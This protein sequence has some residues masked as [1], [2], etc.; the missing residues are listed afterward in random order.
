MDILTANDTPAC[1]PPSF[2]ASKAPIPAQRPDVTGDLDCDVCVIGAG[3][4][5]LSSA[6]HLARK[7]YK[8][9]VLDAHRVGWGASGRNGGHAGNG[10]RVGQTDLERIVGEDRARL[11]WDMGIASV[12]LVRDLVSRHDIACDLGRGII[13]ACN[14]PGAVASSHRNAENLRTKYDYDQIEVL[15]RGRLR[16]IVGTDAYHGGT[17][18]TG[19]AHLDPLA[20]VLGLARAAEAAGAVIHE[21]SRVTGVDQGSPA[22]VRTALARIRARFV[23]LATNGYHGDLFPALSQHVMPINNYIVATEPLSQSCADGLIKGGYA[24]AD[25]KFVI[26]YFRL[27]P[28]RRLIF[29]GGESYG[30]RFPRDIAAKVRRQML[31]IYP[32]LARSRIDYA[33]GGTLGITM[34]RLPYVARSGENILS[35]AGYSGHGV[36]TATLAGSILADAIDGQAARFDI[37]SAL[38]AQKFPGGA[39]LR[40]PLLVLAML[41]YSLRDRL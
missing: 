5:G 41:W 29:G 7:G 3:Y 22:T 38:P 36:A 25:S 13:H 39:A 9:T 26:N 31:E 18:N 6:L 33:W 37:L 2:Y 23:I 10:Q 24:V 21:N 30:Y 28:E 12:D 20:Y 40:H 11:L 34:N 15:D 35:S 8:V 1:Y 32:Q 19:S 14:K 27:S 4:T 17:L 16:S